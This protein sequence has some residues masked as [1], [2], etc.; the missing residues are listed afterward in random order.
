MVSFYKKK[1]A[2]LML[3]AIVSAMSSFGCR[4]NLIYKDVYRDSE[5]FQRDGNTEDKDMG[6][7][8]TDLGRDSYTR[9]AP[10]DLDMGTDMK[11]DMGLDALVSDMGAPCNT[12]SPFSPYCCDKNTVALYHLNDYGSLED[13]CFISDASEN[14]T[15][16]ALGQS[17]DFAEARNFNGTDSYFTITTSP[18]TNF[19]TNDFTVEA[20]FRTTTGLDEG[21]SL[22]GKLDTVP[23]GYR[24][25]YNSDGGSGSGWSCRYWDADG[26]SYLNSGLALNDGE[27][28]HIACS[29]YTLKSGTTVDLYVDGVNIATNTF[30]S[31]RNVDNSVNTLLGNTQFGVGISSQYFD[32]DIDE[33]RI[34]NIARTFE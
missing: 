30:S 7:G 9:D 32:G 19:G 34:S 2:P 14:N 18:E 6:D 20:W 25:S 29:R 27:W 28:H 10:S 17:P 21:E 13:E 15:S 4:D 16:S 22:M 5:V 1:I 26:E 24:I 11:P 31:A 23:V 33:V 3:S 8:N 12:T